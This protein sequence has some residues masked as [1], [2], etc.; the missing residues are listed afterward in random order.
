MGIRLG[1]KGHWGF[2]AMG[3][4]FWLPLALGL[5][6]LTNIARMVALTIQWILFVII[7]LGVLSPFAAMEGVWRNIPLWAL[8]SLVI[9]VGSCNCYAIFVLTYSKDQFHPLLPRAA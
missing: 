5:W 3:A 8:F 7:P 2:G 6:R 1:L 4:F 9:A